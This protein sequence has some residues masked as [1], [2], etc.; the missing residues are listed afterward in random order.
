MKGGRLYKA[1]SKQNEPVEARSSQSGTPISPMSKKRKVE[2]EKYAVQSRRF[3]DDAVKNGTNVCVFCGQKVTKFQGLHHW[4]GRTGD[5][6]LDSRWWS[7]VHNECHVDCF[8]MMSYEKLSEKPWWASF[9]IRLKIFDPTL[10]LYNKIIR[11]GEKANKLNPS[12]FEEKDE[13]LF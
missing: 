11:K 10:E 12:L 9:L 6:L 2:R 8:H 3:F 1:K 13:D 7:T 5:Y 4:K